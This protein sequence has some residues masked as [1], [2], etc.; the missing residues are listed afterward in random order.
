MRGRKA[1]GAPKVYWMT[2]EFNAT[3]RLLY[4]RIA[5]EDRLSSF[6]R[7]RCE[8]IRLLA[9]CVMTASIDRELYDFSVA[10]SREMTQFAAGKSGGRMAVQTEI[11]VFG[12]LPSGEPVHRITIRAAG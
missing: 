6:I 1:A 4:D 10:A 3:A 12:H 5:D 7:R 8:T 2:Q 9:R 11:E